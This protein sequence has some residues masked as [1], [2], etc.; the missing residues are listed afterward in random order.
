[1]GDGG[2]DGLVI[3]HCLSTGK[4]LLIKKRQQRVGIYSVMVLL[5][6]DDPSHYLVQSTEDGLC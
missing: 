4:G 1:M 5:R 6:C 3:Q 2:M